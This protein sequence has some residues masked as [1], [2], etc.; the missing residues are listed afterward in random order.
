MTA[1]K[2]KSNPRIKVHANSELKL[3]DTVSRIFQR[4]VQARKNGDAERVA[5]VTV[6]P[7]ILSTLINAIPL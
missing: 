3:E 6:V 5:G 7:R 1:E 2:M 4:R